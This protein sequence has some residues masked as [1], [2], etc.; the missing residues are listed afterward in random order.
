MQLEAIIDDLGRGPLMECWSALQTAIVANCATHSMPGCSGC[1]GT[2]MN[3]PNTLE[4]L[5]S[6]CQSHRMEM[7]AQYNAMC[8]AAGSGLGHFCTSQNAKYDPPMRMYFHKGVKSKAFLRQSNERPTSF[9]A[10]QRFT[11]PRYLRNGSDLC[12]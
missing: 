3:C 8:T 10:A 2:G 4:S 11:S 9:I 12:S 6:V 7:C 1:T 5:Q